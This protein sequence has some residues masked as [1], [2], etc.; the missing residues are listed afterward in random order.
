MRILIVSQY[1]WPENFRINDIVENLSSNGHD[2]DVLTGYPN[3]PEGELYSEFKKNPQNF[4][5][6]KGAKIFRIPIKLRKKSKKVDLFLNY[7]TFVFSSILF[8]SFK[9]RRKNM[10]LFLPLQLAL[11]QLHYLQYIFLG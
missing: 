2:V 11:L 8:G 10:I 4:Q 6:Y 7:L 5:I 3:Y 1:F 9:L